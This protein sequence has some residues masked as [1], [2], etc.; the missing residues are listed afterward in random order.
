MFCDHEGALGVNLT[1]EAAIDPDRA[2]E[3][4]HAVEGDV[5]AEEGEV[6]AFALAVWFLAV[7]VPHHGFPCELL[8]RRC[9]VVRDPCHERM[10]HVVSRDPVI[11]K[12][13]SRTIVFVLA[14]QG[15]FLGQEQTRAADQ[16]KAGARIRVFCKCPC[17][18]CK[19]QSEPH[20]GIGLE[21]FARI[22]AHETEGH[23]RDSR[24]SPWNGSCWPR[25]ELSNL[26]VDMRGGG[27]E[28][29]LD[30]KPIVAIKIMPCLGSISKRV[31]HVKV[32]A[33]TKSCASSGAKDA[34]EVLWNGEAKLAAEVRFGRGQRWQKGHHHHHGREQECR[35]IPVLSHG[36]LLISSRML[37]VV[38]GVSDPV[39]EN[40]TGRDAPQEDDGASTWR[41]TTAAFPSRVW[42]E[43]S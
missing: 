36:H 16:M 30:A 5:S 22:T 10:P 43:W 4:H 14:K 13:E 19:V 1:F 34:A 21:L 29:C 7:V 26:A 18:L 6:L 32:V 25:C 39:F 27:V 38:V 23:G 3:G 12:A 15:H 40:P 28:V 9:K 35:H 2:V 31:V 24:Q 8:A 33:P 42:D 41:G 11:H 37:L 20:A 17:G